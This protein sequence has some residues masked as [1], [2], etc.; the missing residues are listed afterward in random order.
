MS[1]GASARHDGAHRLG[2]TKAPLAIARAM[3][4]FKSKQLL[5]ITKQTRLEAK[6]V[7]HKKSM[8]H[9][10]SCFKSYEKSIFN[11]RR[12]LQSSYHYDH[13]KHVPELHDADLAPMLQFHT[14]D[15]EYCS[16]SGKY[17]LAL[18]END[19]HYQDLSTP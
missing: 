2:A 1:A 14:H 19:C 4:V 3:H 13:D 16:Q 6:A 9:Y 8:S 7:T 10:D 12:E 5:Q 18:H 11:R 17:V 15:M